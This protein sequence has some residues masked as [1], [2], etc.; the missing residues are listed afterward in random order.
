M[1]SYSFGKLEVVQWIKCNFPL[2]AS[3]L[4]VGACDAAWRKYLLEYE[5]M[6]C[7]EAFKFNW[8]YCKMWYRQAF[9]SDVKDLEYDHY[10]LII[11]GDVIEH[12]DVETAQKVIE[13]AW[14][15]CN[16]M[17]IAVPWEFKQ[18]ELYGNPYER[19]IQDDLTPEIFNQ[20]YP[21][22]TVLHDTGENYCYFHKGET[23]EQH[24]KHT[25]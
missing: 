1:G 2:D 14:P 3:I 4:D 25:G 13:Y 19:H 8:V 12:M 21:G 23:N 5:N 22:F 24:Q 7:V 11:F 20:R 16:D 17:I 18:G 6:D 15:R 9:L 10:D